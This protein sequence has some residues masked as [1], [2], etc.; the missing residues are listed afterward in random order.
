MFAII[1]HQVRDN[2]IPDSHHVSIDHAVVIRFVSSDF[3][4]AMEYYEQHATQF[5]QLRC[6]GYDFTIF[7][8]YDKESRTEWALLAVPE[9]E[10]LST[11]CCPVIHVEYDVL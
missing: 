11:L 9:G 4:A 5:E 8:A 2:S 10:S 7:R 3:D 6:E 1:E